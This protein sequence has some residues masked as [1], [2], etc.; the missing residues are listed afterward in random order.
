MH[1]DGSEKRSRHD[2]N[3][4]DKA[5]AERCTDENNNRDDNDTDSDDDAIDIEDRHIAESTS[6]ATEYAVGPPSNCL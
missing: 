3:N 5:P 4:E 1:R 6:N 2:S